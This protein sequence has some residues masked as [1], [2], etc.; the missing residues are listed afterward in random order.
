MFYFV[1]FFFSDHPFSHSQWIPCCSSSNVYTLT[2]DSFP[3]PRILCLRLCLFCKFLYYRI[4][5]GSNYLRYLGIKILWGY[6]WFVP[7]G[8]INFI[9]QW[10]PFLSIY[11]VTLCLGVLSRY[12]STYLRTVVFLNCMWSPL[13]FQNSYTLQPCWLIGIPLCILTY[14]FIVIIF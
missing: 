2:S 4:D 6:L 12:V 8:S 1:R 9:T 3:Y 14:E 7:F 13:V 11:Y 5:G 10:P